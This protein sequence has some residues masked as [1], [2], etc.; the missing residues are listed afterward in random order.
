MSISVYLASIVIDLAFPGLSSFNAA[1][2]LSAA[3]ANVRVGT[4]RNEKL[5]TAD[6]SGFLQFA[7]III[8]R[9]T[10]IILNQATKIQDS[11]S[12]FLNKRWIC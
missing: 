2:A 10:N 3:P 11:Y 8:A 5:V 9:F 6:C 12:F 1:Y 4:E 7:S